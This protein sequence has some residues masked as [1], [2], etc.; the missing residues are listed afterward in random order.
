LCNG[1]DL[2]KQLL[3]EINKIKIIDTHEHLMERQEIIDQGV[4]VPELFK[5]SYTYLDLLNSGMPK[6]I[7]KNKDNNEIWEMLEDY[8]KKLKLTSSMRTLTRSLKDLYGFDK[9]MVTRD[10]WQHIDN[11]I[12][13]AYKNKDWYREILQDKCNFSISLLDHYWNVDKIPYN[14]KYFLPI[15][16]VDPF[17]LGRKYKSPYPEEQN[18]HTTV[19]EIS[20]EWGVNI[21]TFDEYI[22]LVD[23]SIKKYKH[24]GCPAIKIC[25]AY[26]RSLLF[27]VCEEH[28]ARKLYSKNPDVLSSEEREKLQNY[29]AHY[30]IKEA[31]KNDMPIQIHTGYLARTSILLSNSD[32]EKLNNLFIMYPNAKFVIFHFGYPYYRSA[33]SLVK[34]FKNVYIDFCWV[35]S[36]SDKIAAEMLNEFFD[37]IPYNKIMWGADAERLEDAYSSTVICKEVIAKV[38][39]KRIFD[40]EITFPEATEIAKAILHDTANDL[41]KLRDKIN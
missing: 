19:E 32:P 25:T 14:S 6:D 41:Y 7:F 15:L 1:N 4:G 36:L 22:A 13:E 35:P 31:M 11:V 5:Y 3:D 23:M 18:S 40:G 2:E 20:K 27:E 29:M 12:K 16:R 37:L 38:L 28:V 34:I 30:I 33:L 24:F 8:Q 9:G 26:E 21:N 17:I 10:N 39:S